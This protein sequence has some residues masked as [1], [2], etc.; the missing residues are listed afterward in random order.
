MNQAPALNPLRGPGLRLLLAILVVGLNLR[1][2]I[3]CVGPLLAT[4]QDTV[5][6]NASAAGLLAS[7]PLFA[8]GFVSPYAAPLSRRLG[9]EG[10]LFLSLVAL[11]CGLGI[12]YLPGTLA[13]Y[14]GT[15]FIGVGI[16]ICNVLLPGLLRRE[17]PRH[18]ALV[19]ALFTMALVTVGGLG[20][21]LSIPLANWGGWRF[22][23]VA[24]VLPAVLALVVWAP[25]L[26]HNTRAVAPSASAGASLWRS[27]LAWQVS[28]LMACQSTAFY[29]LIAWLPSML[30]DL[31][32]IS[33]ARAGWILFVYQIFVLLSVM[34]VPLLIHR[35]EDQ[36]W[37]GAGCSSLILL[38]F[39]GVM[40][41]TEQAMLWMILMGLGAGGS[42]VLAMTLF[43]LRVR[44]TEQAVSLSGMAQT[45]GYSMAALTPIL[46]GFIHDQTGSWTIPLLLMTG[47]AVLQVITGYLAGRPLIVNENAAEPR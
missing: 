1:G 17:F 27:A 6:L 24:W 41:Y 18:L 13:L 12:R 34:A 19:T 21:G 9:M 7:L 35:L 26:R 42:L 39:L 30:A 5:G 28:L 37:I 8:F 44:T 22:S 32:G 29:V 36:R 10:T 31:E 25:R 43:S 45:V 20:S 15:A 2:A 23:L 14:L 16:A 4:I 46:I 47:V 11:L 38:G 3:T 33:A 40:L